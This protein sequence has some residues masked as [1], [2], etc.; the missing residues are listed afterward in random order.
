M[1]NGYKFRLY[2]SPAPEQILLRWV[3]C[4]R[5]IYSDAP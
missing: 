3:G 4:Q 1:L 5:L 2:P